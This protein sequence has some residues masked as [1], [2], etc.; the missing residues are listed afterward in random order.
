M[1]TLNVLMFLGAVFRGSVQHISTVIL[2]PDCTD[3]ST[4]AQLLIECS[5]PKKHA[6][7]MLQ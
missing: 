3:Y 6:P 5:A 4:P 2:E 1:E 7:A